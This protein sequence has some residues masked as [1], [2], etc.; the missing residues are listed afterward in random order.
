M[1][2]KR[3]LFEQIENRS[4]TSARYLAALKNL[5]KQAESRKISSYI[6][7]SERKV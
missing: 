3:L 6:L 5:V 1:A 4:E 2:W 7:N